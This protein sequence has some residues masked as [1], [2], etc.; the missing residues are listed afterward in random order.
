MTKEHKEHKKHV[1]DWVINKALRIYFDEGLTGEDVAKRLKR[2]NNVDIDPHA[3]SGWGQTA[4]SKRS[5]R[6]LVDVDESYQTSFQLEAKERKVKRVVVAKSNCAEDVASLGATELIELMYAHRNQ[7]EIHIGFAGGRTPSLLA[8]VL[9]DR[10]A[11]NQVDV[12]K[13]P[14]I[15][16]FHSLVGVLNQADP[17][18]DPNTYPLH[19][20]S[21]PKEIRNRL[22]FRSYP[23]PG[24]VTHSEHKQ[25]STVMSI[26]KAMLF[27][28]LDLAI[29]SCGHSGRSHN[30]FWDHI[31]E[32]CQGDEKMEDLWNQTMKILEANG[33]LGDVAWQPV[34]ANGVVNFAKP[35]PIWAATMLNGKQLFEFT[36]RKGGKCLLLVAPCSSE[37]CQEGTKGSLL[38]GII[39]S[40]NNFVTHVVMDLATARDYAKLL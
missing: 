31:N 13:I 29:V 12:T 19:F 25:L 32:T 33:V 20:Y 17:G 10:L 2:E 40:A 26:R 18:V 36:R 39:G 34:N 28:K 14:K 3:V 35:L 9:A 16:N 22:R 37:S 27:D 5:T 30:S 38:R 24:V 1:A 6:Y 7:T 4:R 8:S 21:L 11:T 23:C 15:I